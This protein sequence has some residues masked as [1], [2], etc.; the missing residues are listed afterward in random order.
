[1]QTPEPRKVVISC[2]PPKLSEAVRRTVLPKEVSMKR[3]LSKTGSSSC[4]ACTAKK[5]S[6][7]KLECGSAF[8]GALRWLANIRVIIWLFDFVKR[9]IEQGSPFD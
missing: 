2:L 3:K 1:M 6:G 7:A 4:S 8:S 5:K 9:W